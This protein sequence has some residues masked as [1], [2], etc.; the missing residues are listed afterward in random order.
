MQYDLGVDER[1]KAAFA[2]AR[3]VRGGKVTRGMTLRRWR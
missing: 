2:D 1:E 3:G